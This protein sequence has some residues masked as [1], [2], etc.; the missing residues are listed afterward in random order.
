MRKVLLTLVA[1]LA[2]SLLCF[3]QISLG[4]AGRNIVG[5]MP[6]PSCKP[7]EEGIVVVDVVVD[8]YGTV[9]RVAIE[10]DGT[11]FKDKTVL[12]ACGEAAMATRFNVDASAPELQEGT[13]YYK[14]NNG[15]SGKYTTIKSFVEKEYNGV[16][17]VKGVFDGVVDYNKLIFLINEDDYIIPI[18]LIKK[19]LG[20]EKRFRALDLQKGDTLTVKGRFSTIDVNYESYKGLKEAMIIGRKETGGKDD[21]E[22]KNITK[23]PFQI[24]EDK[25]TF[26]GGD[27]NEFSK[28]VNQNLVYPKVAT[29]QMIEGKVMVQFTVEA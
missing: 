13:L 11:T 28:W 17:C 19:D 26:N 15:Y 20:A 12:E 9:K 4:M 29:R 18:Q 25:P 14:F 27:A 6:Q 10:A 2:F 16:F 21:D 8:R 5:T 22:P 3:S 1:F 23:V 7:L 24:V